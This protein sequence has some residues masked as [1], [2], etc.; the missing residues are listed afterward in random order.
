MSHGGR[1]QDTGGEGHCESRGG[2]WSLFLQTPF[3]LPCCSCLPNSDGTASC[4]C[5]AGFQGNGT[6][7]TGKQRKEFA[8]GWQGLHGLLKDSCSCSLNGPQL[9]VPTTDGE[10]HI[11]GQLIVPGDRKP[12]GH[13]LDHNWDHL[14]SFKNQ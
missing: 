8:G 4:K 7:C 11:I 13:G 1:H 12:N 3:A 2:R 5:A 14:G 9:L 10:S 6:I